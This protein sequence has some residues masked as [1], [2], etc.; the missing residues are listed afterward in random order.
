LATS[1]RSHSGEKGFGE[2]QQQGAG[3]TSCVIET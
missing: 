1:S 2:K 3:E